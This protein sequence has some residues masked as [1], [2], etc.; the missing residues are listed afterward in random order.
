MWKIIATQVI[1]HTSCENSLKMKSSNYLRPENRKN[2]KYVLW[3]LFLN[4][5]T[6]E[7]FRKL[8]ILSKSPPCPF[9]DP[10]F[11]STQGKRVCGSPFP[12]KYQLSQMSSHEN[13][14]FCYRFPPKKSVNFPP[15]VCL[16]S[17]ASSSGENINSG[18]GIVHCER[19]GR[20]MTSRVM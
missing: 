13:T 12:Q 2:I 10:S 18:R 7:C 1:I 17:P 15:Q 19:L 9:W 3:T 8:K 11:I 5:A 4:V 20:D 16:I 6:F 14:M